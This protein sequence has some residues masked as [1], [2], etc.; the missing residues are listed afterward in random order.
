MPMGRTYILLSVPDSFAQKMVHFLHNVN[1][2]NSDSEPPVVVEKV[3]KKKEEYAA[4]P[5]GEDDDC[6]T[7]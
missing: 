4:T 2:L 6:T 5:K 1:M 3:F 7:G